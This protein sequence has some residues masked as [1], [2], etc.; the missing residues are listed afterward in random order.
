[1]A[2]Y[3]ELCGAACVDSGGSACEACPR[4]QQLFL[5]LVADTKTVRLDESLV[6]GDP[7]GSFADAELRDRE[8]GIQ[9]LAAGAALNPISEP[10][11]SPGTDPPLPSANPIPWALPWR[12]L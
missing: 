1:M 11:H 7:F 12:H 2:R 10:R 8:R 9:F 5:G 6:A 3:E 4:C